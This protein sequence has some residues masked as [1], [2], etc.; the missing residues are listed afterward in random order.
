MYGNLIGS[1]E[2]RSDLRKSDRIYGNLIGSTEIKIGSTE[3]RSD[4][5]VADP[6][7][8]RKEGSKAEEVEGGLGSSNRAKNFMNF[9]TDTDFC[10]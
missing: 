8:G 9:L 10:R 7:S 3:I 2:I 4:L 1:T 5:R 6:M